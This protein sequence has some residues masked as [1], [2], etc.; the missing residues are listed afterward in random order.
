L[1]ED[2]M[3]LFGDYNNDA[4]PDLSLTFIENDLPYVA[5]LRN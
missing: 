3:L 5:L 1:Y 2:A 4:Y